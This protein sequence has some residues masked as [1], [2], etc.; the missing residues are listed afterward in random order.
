M[1]SRPSTHFA[2]IRY[3]KFTIIS[4]RFVTIMLFIKMNVK[5]W[6]NKKIYSSSI[7]LFPY[8]SIWF[9]VYK[10]IWKQEIAF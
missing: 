1:L 2:L 9:A 4:I 6:K 3:S 5:E 7:S 10:S 8:F